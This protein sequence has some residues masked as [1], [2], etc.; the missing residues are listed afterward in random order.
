M[1]THDFWPKVKTS[2]GKK[3]RIRILRP[4]L[5][6]I[7]ARV[8]KLKRNQRVWRATLSKCKAGDH[9]TQGLCNLNLARIAQGLA[10]VDRYIKSLSG[11]PQ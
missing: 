3:R 6:Q 4:T 11:A 10:N 7:E 1:R 5:Q 8:R 9:E 2:D